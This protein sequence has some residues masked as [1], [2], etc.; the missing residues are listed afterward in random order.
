MLQTSRLLATGVF[1]IG[2]LAGASV[3][4]AGRPIPR[5]ADHGRA[6]PRA[7]DHDRAIPRA[8]ASDAGSATPSMLPPPYRIGR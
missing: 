4:G 1:L 5:G 7:A 6:I 3:C 2:V 8:A